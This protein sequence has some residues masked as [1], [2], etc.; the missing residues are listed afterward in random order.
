MVAL[1]A[2][3]FASNLADC[4]IRAKLPPYPHQA[5]P[6]RATGFALGAGPNK[7]GKALRFEFTQRD[8]PE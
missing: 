1:A 7:M 8:I 6:T 2:S 5:Q 4:V 3:Q